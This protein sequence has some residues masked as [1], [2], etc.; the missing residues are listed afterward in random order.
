MRR[1]GRAILG[2]LGGGAAAVALAVA[3]AWL[4]DISQAEGAYA[5]AVA[6][7]WVPLGAVAGAVLAAVLPRRR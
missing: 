1:L 3:A 2:L 5:M 4:F 7:F 6:F